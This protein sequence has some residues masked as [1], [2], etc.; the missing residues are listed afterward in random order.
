MKLRTKLVLLFLLG[1]GVVAGSF[2]WHTMRKQQTIA[3]VE[4]RDC[5]PSYRNTTI[6]ETLA[7]GITERDLI[8]RLGQPVDS[9]G[10]SLYFEAGAGEQGKIEVELDG[11]RKAKRFACRGNLVKT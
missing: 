6:C 2:L 1:L 3:C 10:F 11:S 8:F 4:A 7:I 9:A 5:K